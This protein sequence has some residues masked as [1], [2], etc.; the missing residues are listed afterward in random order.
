MKII[1]IFLSYWKGLSYLRLF[2]FLRLRSRV[3][4]IINILKA[5]SGFLVILCFL[6]ISFWLMFVNYEMEA[7]NIL[8]KSFIMTLNIIFGGF[9]PEDIHYFSGLL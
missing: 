2:S 1:L 6:F 4:Q 7:D 3:T 8:M 5:M 9:V